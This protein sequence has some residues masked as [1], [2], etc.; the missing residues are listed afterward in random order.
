MPSSI[1]PVAIVATYYYVVWYDIFLR[2][3]KKKNQFFLTKWIFISYEIGTK[4]P[5]GWNPVETKICR[6][7]N[8]LILQKHLV[9]ERHS[10]ER[11]SSSRKSFLDILDVFGFVVHFFH[12]FLQV[13]ED[14]RYKINDLT[15]IINM[16]ILNNFGNELEA[17]K[18]TKN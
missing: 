18:S 12:K 13:Y 9:D 14:I 5:C 16:I 10:K 2:G 7:W 6:A 11:H 8:H 4:A 15:V 1:V 3:K 17:H